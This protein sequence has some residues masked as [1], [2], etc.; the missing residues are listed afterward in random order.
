MNNI[1][2]NGYICIN[3]FSAF[4]IIIILLIIMYIVNKD[5]YSKIYSKINYLQSISE[6]KINK[7]KKNNN[8]KNKNDDQLMKR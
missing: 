1:C 4:D 5:S 3:H 2:P 8:N 6:K 7:L